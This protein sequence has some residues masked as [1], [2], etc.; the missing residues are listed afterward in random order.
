MTTVLTEIT[1]ALT[2]IDYWKLTTLV[3]ATFAAYVAYEQYRLGRERF[4]LE[5]FEK[6]FGVFAAIRLL[7][8]HII[9]DGQLNDLK[10]V[11]EYR[12][13]IG[14]AKFLFNEDITDYLE[15]IY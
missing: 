7:L 10:Y 14:E 13:A 6:R 9:R 5:L 4:K 12:A 15:D 2:G 3:L 8:S 11:W 1:G